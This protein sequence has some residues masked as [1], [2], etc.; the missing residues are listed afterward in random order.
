MDAGSCGQLSPG[1]RNAGWHRQCQCAKPPQPLQLMSTV[2]AERMPVFGC[3]NVDKAVPVCTLP[4]TLHCIG[5]QCECCTLD[6]GANCPP[7]LCRCH[8]KTRF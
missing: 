2:Q 4:S 7:L 1:S 8:W 6:G 3:A 5:Q